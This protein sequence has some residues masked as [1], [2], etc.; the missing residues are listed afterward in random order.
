MDHIAPN[1][2]HKIGEKREPNNDNV[3]GSGNDDN[4]VEMVCYTQNSLHPFARMLNPLF[5][6]CCKCMLRIYKNEMPI[7]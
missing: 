3:N 2:M 5:G 7:Y 1:R 4:Y 6:I